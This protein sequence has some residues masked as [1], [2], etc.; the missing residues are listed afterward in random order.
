MELKECPHCRDGGAPR[1]M[2]GA[3]AY[4]E[5]ASCGMAGPWYTSGQFAEHVDLKHA[6]EAWNGLPRRRKT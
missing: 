4:V 2:S 5:C 3:S 1:A 6:V